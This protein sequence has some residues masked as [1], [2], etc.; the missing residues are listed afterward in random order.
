MVRAGEPAGLRSRS[1]SE[2]RTHWLGPTG[3]S[4][5]RG[6]AER[7]LEVFKEELA[8][9]QQLLCAADTY[10]VLVIL[11]ALDAA[12]KD[13]TIKHVMSRVNPQ[14]CEVVSFKPPSAEELSH[15]FLWRCAK[16]LPERGR[17]WIFNRSYRALTKR[18]SLRRR[19]PGLRGTSCRLITSTACG[20]LSGPS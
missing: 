14:G 2:T 13:G 20:R 12:G 19:L 8:S 6:L 4:S 15:D 9:A 10:A 7:D 18:P 5:P 16:A 1:T 17:I 11:Q 3:T